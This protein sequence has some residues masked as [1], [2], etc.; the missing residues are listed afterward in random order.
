MF[1]LHVKYGIRFYTLHEGRKGMGA[2]KH[3]Q[4]NSNHQ[5]SGNEGFFQQV[6]SQ[7]VKHQGVPNRSD[8][9]A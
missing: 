3:E 8:L 6:I 2:R 4:T 7:N 9:S 5:P 1:H